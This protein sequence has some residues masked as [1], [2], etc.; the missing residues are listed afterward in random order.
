MPPSTFFITG[1]DTDCG[2]THVTCALIRALR[3]QGLRVAP[4]KP[5]AAGAESID[6]VL[7]NED[8]LKLIAAAGG[9]WDYQ[10]VNPYCLPDPVSPHLTARDVGV[11]IDLDIIQQGAES[12]AAQADCLVVEGAGGWLVPLG[13]GLAIADIAIALRAPVVLVVGLRLG[14]LNH[15][16]LSAQA[17]QQS[18]VPMAGWIGSQVDP[19]MARLADNLET[20]RDCLPMPYLGYFP[21]GDH[22]GRDMRFTPPQV[23]SE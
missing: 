6:G 7:R 21:F 15:A 18:G 23:P 16:R 12:L 2:K 17:I 19:E 13:H 9:G 1:T 20:L 11:Q 14:C 5:V 3:A 8:A 22:V 10:Q 4:Y